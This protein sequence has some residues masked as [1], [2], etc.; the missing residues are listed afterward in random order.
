M[1][2][3]LRIDMI[4]GRVV[5]EKSPTGATTRYVWD[6]ADRLVEIVLPNGRRKRYSYNAYGKVTESIDETGAKT[7]YEYGLNSHLVSRVIQP[8]GS[9]LSYQYNNA[10]GFVSEIT[11]E[12]GD[13]YYIDY[14]LMVW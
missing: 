12:N 1:A 2:V 14:F 10:K 3:V 7:V 9:T 5:E 13:S 8:D 4:F 6:D 11:N